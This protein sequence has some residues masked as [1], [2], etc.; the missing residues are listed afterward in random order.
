MHLRHTSIQKNNFFSKATV[1]LFFAILYIGS[2]S[3][4]A[5]TVLQK[6]Y[7]DFGPNDVTNGNV[8]PGPDANSN[9]WNNPTNPAANTFISLVNAANIPTGFNLVITAALLSNGIQN[10]GLLSPNQILLGELAIATATQDYFFTTTAGSFKLTGLNT[11]KAYKFYLFGSRNNADPARITAYTVTGLTTN[12]GNLQ[13]SGTNLGGAGYNGNNS[14]F[15]ISEAIIPNATGEIS[16]SIA[17]FSGGFGYLNMMKVEELSQV[18]ASSIAITGN[19]ISTLG[20]TTQMSLPYTPATTTARPASWY[21]DDTEIA[22]ISATGVV[23]PK[24]NG[25]VI[26]SA[27]ILQNAVPLTATKTI[28]ISNQLSE[29]YV[30]GTATIN[31]NNIATAIPMNRTPDVNGFTPGLFELYT[32]ISSSGT[33]QLYTTQNSSTAIVYGAGA[34][35]GTIQTSGPAI[36][37]ADSGNVLIRVNLLTNTYATYPIDTLKYSQMGSSVS[38]GFGATNRQGYPYQ[39][40]QLQNQRFNSGQGKNWKLSNISV[41]GNNTFWVQGRW[42]TDLLNDKSRYVVY[43]LSLS[44]EGIAGG[45]QSAFD[46]FKK[47]MLLLIAKARSVGKIPI[48]TNAYSN[49]NF[50]STEYN[51]TKQ[52]NLLMH[53]WDVPSVNL[54]G[55]IDDGAGRWAFGYQNDAAHPNHAGHTEMFYTMVPSLFDALSNGKPQPIKLNGTYLS[56]GKSVTSDQLSFIPENIVHSFTQSFDIRTSQPGTIASFT[57]GSA[58]GKLS[59][60]A[61]TGYAVYNSPNG[62]TIAGNRIVND[63]QWHKITIT[64]FYA[65]GET[66]LYTDSMEAGRINEK[67][68]ATNFFLH[69]PTAPLTID[70]RDWLFYRSGMNGEEI[71]QLSRGKMLKSSLEL[72]APLDGQALLGN[73]TLINLAQ[74]TNKAKTISS[75]QSIYIFNG[76][77]DWSN[78]VNWLNNNKPPLRLT[79]GAEVRIIPPAGAQCTLDVP[80]YFLY[81][82]FLYVG[83]HAKFTV[84]NN[85][86]IYQNPVFLFVPGAYQNWS[87]ATAPLIN[88]VEGQP[89]KFDGFINFPGPGL[90]FKYTNAP[91]WNSTNYGNGNTSGTFSTSPAATNLSVPTAGYYYL[92]A[93]INSAVNGWTATK[94]NWSVIG[95]ATSAGAN[96]DLLMNYDT[97]SQ[98]WQ[99]TTNLT[100]SG[101][102]RFRANNQSIITMGVNATGKLAFINNPF[103]GN[104]ATVQSITVPTDG[105]YTIT[106]DLS[107]S[108]NF[109]Y[110][111]TRN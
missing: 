107:R 30:S 78:A 3:L 101:S 85:I 39:Y 48:V 72:Y 44:N 88:E 82:A 58:K 105:N 67:L 90:A 63:G 13:S 71:T 31:G 108:G 103:R 77:G 24:K 51:F 17:A 26:I 110:S 5:Q 69:D 64:H 16:I 96:T 29:L 56:M 10:G 84:E 45:G 109:T 46:Q 68:T 23:T 1:L 14:S 60:A 6:I 27:S 59:L 95:D 40:G 104:N 61:S 52:M 2:F 49:G 22:T 57:Q 62:G 73:D 33:L 92:T 76:N 89:K 32:K 93:D 35:G 21:V 15:F 54:L 91:D 81:D 111:A 42:D 97:A 50:G 12:A 25:T 20:A 38:N 100:A 66:I 87:P 18:D 83:S 19:D 102:F 55:A 70:Y 8:T 41:D 43:A 4:T 53:E 28:V 74:S 94:A 98:T 86:S 7:V 80:V 36:D 47:N 11:S 65:R 106:L 99:L 9:Y 37:P 79:A 75:R 34:S